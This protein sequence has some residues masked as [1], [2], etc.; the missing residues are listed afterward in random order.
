LILPLADPSSDRWDLSRRSILREKTENPI[1]D[2]PLPL[3]YTLLSP[4]RDNAHKDTEVYHT[5]SEG[6]GKRDKRGCHE[7][8]EWEIEEPGFPYG[9]MTTTGATDIRGFSKR[10][11]DSAGLNDSGKRNSWKRLY[12]QRQN[13]M[14]SSPSSEVGDSQG[15]HAFL[16]N[17]RDFLTYFR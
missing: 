9:S 15:E 4:I 3:P 2:P 17:P 6:K 7:E 14:N 11:A 13:T 5:P 10:T 1:S 12:Q 8:D 16:I